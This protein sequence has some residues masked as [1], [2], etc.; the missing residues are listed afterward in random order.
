VSLWSVQP[1]PD[2]I[3]RVPPE[4]AARLAAAQERAR[5][6]LRPEPQP[7]SPPL[8]PGLPAEASVTQVTPVTAAAERSPVHGLD[9]VTTA[10]E[11]TSVSSGP[12]LSSPK[13]LTLTGLKTQNRFDALTWNTLPDPG[14]PDTP[15]AVPETIDPVASGLIVPPAPVSGPS[16]RP[17]DP[18]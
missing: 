12:S 3:N 15:C 5:A 7:A 17:A 6:L 4:V 9:A 13:R 11:E 18:S 1:D 8:S 16:Q 14:D 10:M 2:W